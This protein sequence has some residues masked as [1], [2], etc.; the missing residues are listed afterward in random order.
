MFD[1]LRRAVHHLL[2]HCLDASA[3]GR[4]ADRRELAGQPELADQAQAVVQANAARC[5][6]ASLVSN[7]PEGRRS[8][9]R[10][11]LISGGTARGCRGAC[12]ARS[13]RPSPHR[14]WSTSLRSRSRGQQV[15]ALLVD[16]ALG[17]PHHQAQRALGLLPGALDLQVQQSHP[18]ARADFIEDAGGLGRA[19]QAV[20]S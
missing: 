2:Q 6:T 20:L 19:T 8:R 17:H 18:L 14:G 15:L 4:V 12:R 7:L 9:S 5:T 16:R 11:V 1:E 13:R 3:L 10:S